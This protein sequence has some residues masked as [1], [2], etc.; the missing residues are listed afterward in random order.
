MDAGQFAWRRR[1]LTEVLLF[2]VFPFLLEGQLMEPLLTRGLLPRT[3]RAL[4]P[5]KKGGEPSAFCQWIT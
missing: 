3:K 1:V 4:L 5:R 2:L